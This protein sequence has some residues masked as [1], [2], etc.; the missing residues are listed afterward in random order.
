M[1]KILSII[2]IGI[3][4]LSG[5]GAG[6]SL[7]RETPMKQTVISDEYDMVI[8]APEMFSD[9]LQLLIDHKN[10]VGIQTFLETTEDIYSMYDGRDKAEQIK[11]FILDSAK[12][13]VFSMCCWLVTSR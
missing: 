9:A 11:Y 2:S 7:I 5:L 3:L 10:S 12:I 4:F 8:I 13:R 6:A 1:K